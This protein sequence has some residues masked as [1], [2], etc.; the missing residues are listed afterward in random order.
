MKGVLYVR[1]N[2][3]QSKIDL[4]AQ[5]LTK[6]LSRPCLRD[7]V[8]PALVTVDDPLTFEGFNTTG[9]S[10]VRLPKWNTF[11]R[12]S[13]LLA[14]HVVRSSHVVSG[15]NG[16]DVTICLNFI[17]GHSAARSHVHGRCNRLLR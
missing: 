10:A 8:N 12:Y 1:R 13:G 17:Y 3:F 5:A 4:Q 15:A 2:R 6:D 7:K 9:C 16:I 14:S 11:R